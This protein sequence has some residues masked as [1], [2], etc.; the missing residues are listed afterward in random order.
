MNT[1]RHEGTGRPTYRRHYIKDVGR[2]VK[3]GRSSCYEK[4][5]GEKTAIGMLSFSLGVKRKVNIRNDIDIERG[6]VW[7]EVHEVKSEMVLSRGMS[8]C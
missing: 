8:R 3:G 6:P 7:A 2:P 1:V 5:T 4:Y